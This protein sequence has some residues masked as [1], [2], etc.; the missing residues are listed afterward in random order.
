MT[1]NIIKFASDPNFDPSF[2]IARVGRRRAAA[3]LVGVA[4][5]GPLGFSRQWVFTLRRGS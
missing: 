4:L 1:A 2:D 3:E 5:L